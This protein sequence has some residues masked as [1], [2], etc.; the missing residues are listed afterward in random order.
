MEAIGGV[1]SVAQLADF[2]KSIVSDLYHLELSELHT[3]S[4]NL[5]ECPFYH[6]LICLVLKLNQAKYHPVISYRKIMRK[7][8]SNV[9]FHRCNRYNQMSDHTRRPP[10]YLLPKDRQMVWQNTHLRHILRQVQL[11]LST[12]FKM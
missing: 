8:T 3:M 1:A 10:I 6:N 11:Q 4:D 9:I 5:V 12:A 2:A 7:F